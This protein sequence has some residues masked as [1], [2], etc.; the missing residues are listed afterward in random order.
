MKPKKTNHSQSLL[1]Q[2]R[3]S[4][5]LNPNH[6]LCIL[7][8][9]VDWTSFEQEFTELFSEKRGAPGRPVRLVVGLLMLENMYG[10]SDEEVVQMWVENP[11]WQFFCGYDYLQWKFP[12][13]PSS[14]TRWRKRLGSEGMEKILS[15]TII[16]AIEVGASKRSSF[17]KVIVD[18]TV[19]PKNITYPTDSKLYYRGIQTVV[20]M[21]KRHNI[22][23]RQTYTFLS[24]RA[25]RKANCYA[26]A[27]QMK[28]AKKERKRLKTY[29]GRVFRDIERQM[30]SNNVLKSIF[31][32][33][34]KVIKEILTQEKNSKNKIY[35]IHE[36]CAT[37]RLFTNGGRSHVK[38]ID[39]V[40]SLPS[41]EQCFGNKFAKRRQGSCRP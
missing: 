8:K 38:S 13:N 40:H 29:L 15:S 1:F 36:P 11:Y 28:R 10:I 39:P 27:R 9:I 7:S 26:H 30:S 22:E 23:L 12:I 35:S 21:A 17:K 14:L 3:L 5:E 37:R 31:N 24:K 32:P 25:L 34:L 19:M 41:L 16:A 20:R 18:T 4:R 6:E 2:P 33:V